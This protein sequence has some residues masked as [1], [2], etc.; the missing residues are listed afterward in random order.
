MCKNN[1]FLKLIFF[2]KSVDTIY[3]YPFVHVYLILKEYQLKI[4]D[5][6]YGKINILN[7]KNIK[8]FLTKKIVNLLKTEYIYI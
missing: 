6:I 7:Y 3:K 4:N 2:K 8:S 1:Y 5:N